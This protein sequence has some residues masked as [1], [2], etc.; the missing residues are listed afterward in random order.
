[1]GNKISKEWHPTT[2][3]DNPAVHRQYEPINN[4]KRNE[5]GE[6]HYEVRV[7]RST[8]LS[9]VAR[10]SM[11]YRRILIHISISGAFRQ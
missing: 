4:I 8:L 7:K 1:M 6:T 3:L 11:L 2:I 9:I 5:N 10:S